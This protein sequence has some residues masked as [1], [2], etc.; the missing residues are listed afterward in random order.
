MLL[1]SYPA[2]I[3]LSVS[4]GVIVGIILGVVATIVTIT[5]CWSKFCRAKQQQ[6]V[7]EAARLFVK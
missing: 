4:T 6:P 1:V 2:H 5:L 7:N 3:T